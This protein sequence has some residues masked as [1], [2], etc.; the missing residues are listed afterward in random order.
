MDL[1]GWRARIDTVDRSLVDLLNERMEYC[2]EIGKI[3]R[4]EGRQVQDEEREREVVERLSA[5]NAG[6]IGDDAIADIFTRIMAE[7]RA[8]ES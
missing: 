6:P 5:Y 8:L 2:L 1:E 4:G 7:A 3:K